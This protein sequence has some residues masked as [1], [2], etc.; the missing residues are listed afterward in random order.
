MIDE[1]SEPDET[2]E[3]VDLTGFIDTVENVVEIFGSTDFSGFSTPLVF[4]MRCQQLFYTDES[5][6]HS[7][8]NMKNL[9]DALCHLLLGIMEEVEDSDSVQQRV[10]E[11]T[12]NELIPEL[13]ADP[14]VFVP[15]WSKEGIERLEKYDELSDEEFWDEFFNGSMLSEICEEVELVLAYEKMAKMKSVEELFESKDEE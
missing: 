1:T 2:G 9:V 11:T 8:E 4:Q 7:L 6:D 3:W 13:R 14:L 12:R 5:N 15:S 10:V